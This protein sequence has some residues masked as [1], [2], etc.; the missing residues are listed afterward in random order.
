MTKNKGLLSIVMDEE[1]EEVLAVNLVE[2]F[3]DVAEAENEPFN[4]VNLENLLPKITKN[5]ADIPYNPPMSIEEKIKLIEAEVPD[6]LKSIIPG[7]EMTA[8]IMANEYNENSKDKELIIKSIV[9][10]FGDLGY[11]EENLANET[12]EKL[13]EIHQMDSEDMHR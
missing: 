5:T 12:I 9:A 3:E 4:E 1:F 10:R 13:M 8:A 2:E 11:T 7:L 6:E